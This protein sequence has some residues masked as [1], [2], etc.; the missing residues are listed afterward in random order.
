[1]IKVLIV[2]ESIYQRKLYSELLL[3]HKIIQVVHIAKNFQEATKAIEEHQFDV[4]VLDIDIIN[5]TNID[6]FKLLTHSVQV[7]IIFLVSSISKLTDPFLRP[8]SSYAF[9]Y[10]IKPSGVWKEELPKIKDRLIE[11]VLIASKS[12]FNQINSQVKLLLKKQFIRQIQKTNR[13]KTKPTQNE[14]QQRFEDF[15]FD[16]S[17]VDV[18]NL[19]SNAIVMGASVGGPR[20]LEGILEKIP[21]N[22]SSPI[23]VV[24]HMN[25]F[26]MRQ[27]TV[28]L[29]E[30]CNLKVKIG[31]NGEQ[32]RPGVIY[33]SHGDKHMQI[34]G[35]NGKPCLRL[36]EGEPVNFCRPSVDVL[37]YS[38]ARVY[39]NNTL[40][41]LL[42]G[43]GKD[44]VAGLKT[45]KKAGGKTI[46][47]S[48]ETAVLY[49]MPKAAAE[50][51]VADLIVPNYKIKDYMIN[52]AKNFTSRLNN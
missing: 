35:K 24:Q 10:I 1:M 3:S 36:F 15:F 2:E 51:G 6:N 9:D 13:I 43:M 14:F 12:N 22:F 47:E 23:L 31:A 44:G 38:A 16:R 27:F 45:I 48:E 29:K 34:I 33:I 30:K 41:I 18:K 19:D 32:I 20:T 40:G 26:F 50:S 7:P 8:H 21:H 17:P 4:I 46:A 42:T 5:L 11:K 25:H 37:F 49:G 28:R 52:F 39:K